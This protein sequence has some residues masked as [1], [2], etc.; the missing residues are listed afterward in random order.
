MVE[1]F[2]RLD[3]NLIDLKPPKI[4][5]LAGFDK[6]EEPIK[7]EYLKKLASAM[8]HA[9]KLI[10][11]ERNQLVKLMVKK[12][13]QLVKLAANVRANDAMLQSEVTR[14]NEQKQG[15]HAEVSRLNARIRELEVGNL[16]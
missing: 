10:Q 9:A 11:N 5:F 1:G 16:D 7:I 6:K 3:D 4:R 12:E 13:Q 14:M 8:N 2:H 15:F